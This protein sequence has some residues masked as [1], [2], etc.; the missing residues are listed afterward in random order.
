MDPAKPALAISFREGLM[1]TL[2]HSQPPISSNNLSNRPNGQTAALATAP[3]EET[4][5]DAFDTRY[6]KS[7]GSSLLNYVTSLDFDQF[8]QHLHETGYDSNE[9]DDFPIVPLS[10]LGHPE[11]WEPFY[12]EVFARGRAAINDQIANEAVPTLDTAAVTQASKVEQHVN[13]A[14]QVLPCV[15]CPDLTFDTDEERETHEALEHFYCRPCDR[16]F[17]EIVSYEQ[18][19]LVGRSETLLPLSNI[20]SFLALRVGCSQ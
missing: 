14:S 9:E 18:V 3:E 10:T 15:V 8:S 2:S 12:Q 17:S 13:R 5:D 19:S 7:T 1:G 20:A 4:F 11:T 16:F 6:K